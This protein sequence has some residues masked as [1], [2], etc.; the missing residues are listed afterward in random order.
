MQHRQFLPR[1]G[2]GLDTGEK[3][4][5]PIRPQLPQRYDPFVERQP[6]LDVIEMRHDTPLFVEL[7]TL[8]S[9]LLFKYNAFN[10]IHYIVILKTNHNEEQKDDGENKDDWE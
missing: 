5:R 9:L 1:S 8:T 3:C 4:A 7:L 6:R 2:L 10:I